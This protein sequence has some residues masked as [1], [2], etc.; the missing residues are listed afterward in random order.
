MCVRASCAFACLLSGCVLT[1][2]AKQWNER[3]GPDG[4]PVYYTGISKIG[5]NLL[6]F[7]PLFGDISTD[8][9]VDDLTEHVEETGG[10][11]VRIVQGGTENY[12]YGWPP[13]TWILTPVIATVAAEYR[14][15]EETR[16]QD[17]EELEK[18]GGDEPRWYK[19]WSW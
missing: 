8:G 14:P 7:V 1:S 17:A 6:V 4:V 12:W 5:F 11:H 19:P 2:T 9:L 18:A 3:V 13:F 15:D 16:Q 10:D